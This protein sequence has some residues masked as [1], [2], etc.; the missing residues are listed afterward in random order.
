MAWS[1]AQPTAAAATPNAVAGP[2]RMSRPNPP[3]VGLSSMPA[4]ARSLAQRFP[5]AERLRIARR[6]VGILRVAADIVR[7][8]PRTGA[9]AVFGEIDD[10]GDARHIGQPERA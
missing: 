9:L 2:H 3:P 8:L 1:T 5:F 10:D 4:L 7:D 6:H